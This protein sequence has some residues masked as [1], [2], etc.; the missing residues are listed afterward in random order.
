MH[1]KLGIHESESE[2]GL[3]ERFTQEYDWIPLKFKDIRV[4]Q[5]CDIKYCYFGGEVQR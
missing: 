3:L 2:L 1:E 4:D 5:N